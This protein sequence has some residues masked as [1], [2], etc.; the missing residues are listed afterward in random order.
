MPF[1]IVALPFLFNSQPL[2]AEPN[3]TDAFTKQYTGTYRGK[4]DVEMMISEELSRKELALSN[5]MR[6]TTLDATELAR[7]DD[8]K[9]KLFF[10]LDSQTELRL[11]RRANIAL[12]GE[13]V[14]LQEAQETTKALQ[15]SQA[16]EL[17]QA[18][19]D[20]GVLRANLEK[21]QDMVKRLGDLRAKE[22]QQEQLKEKETFLL[23]SQAE[24]QLMQR[25]IIRLNMALRS[26]RVRLQEAQ[27]TTEALQKFQAEELQQVL[28]D[29]DSLH[30]NQGKNQNMIKT[31]QDFRAKEEQEDSKDATTDSRKASGKRIG[32]NPSTKEAH[33]IFPQQ[34]TGQERQAVTPKP[35]PHHFRS[36]NIEEDDNLTRADKWP[37]ASAKTA[38]HIKFQP[39]S[40]PRQQLRSS[41]TTAT[42]AELKIIIQS[43]FGSWRQDMQH[44]QRCYY[45]STLRPLCRGEIIQIR[46]RYIANQARK[47]VKARILSSTRTRLCSRL[48]A[49]GGKLFGCGWRQASDTNEG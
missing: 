18:L 22:K 5:R 35:G 37:G 41:P 10:S 15:K 16:E 17:H 14:R 12:H 27:E 29:N 9:E 36:S 8:L 32:I 42:V 23:T 4:S 13:K 26:E 2:T 39:P 20:N 19:K 45:S 34:T 7:Y 3:Y 33:A 1:A 40:R 44:L 47:V 49:F 38:Y 24:L 31:L 48:S 25:H 30:A 21:T 6:L 11:V 46:R 43:T 28:K